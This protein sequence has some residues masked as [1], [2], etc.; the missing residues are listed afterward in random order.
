MHTGFTNF[1]DGFTALIYH[2]PNRGLG[3]SDEAILRDRPRA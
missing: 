1:V 2:Q 3:W